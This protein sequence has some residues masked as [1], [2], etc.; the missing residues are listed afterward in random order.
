MLHNIVS[1]KTKMYITE[2]S[3]LI[4]QAR[5]DLHDCDEDTLIYVSQFW[6]LPIVLSSIKTQLKS[7]L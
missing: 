2:I 7:T 1:Q 6:T 5:K 3:L 4:Y